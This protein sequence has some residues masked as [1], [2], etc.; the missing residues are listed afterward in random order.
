MGKKERSSGD[1]WL[2]R[3]GGLALAAALTVLVVALVAMP[4]LPTRVAPT[5]ETAV[6]AS[7]AGSSA[8]GRAGVL[9]VT[10]EPTAPEE[11]TAGATYTP[12]ATVAVSPTLTATLGMSWPEYDWW[13]AGTVIAEVKVEEVYPVRANNPSGIPPT[14]DPS[15]LQ[16]K[17]PGGYEKREYQPILVDVVEWYHGELP[18]VNGLLFW[19]MV[20]W[21]GD[22]GMVNLRHT[23]PLDRVAPGDHAIV[24][25]E[26]MNPDLASEQPMWAYLL[27]EA[28]RLSTPDQAVRAADAGSW[29]QFDGDRAWNTHYGSIWTIEELRVEIERLTGSSP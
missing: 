1:G 24:F 8:R 2:V 4:G 6:P 14:R 25:F 29:Y 16:F 20:T 23:I 7:G 15:I 27:D 17:D 19:D 21:G 11:P 9:S 22:W 18:G 12:T 5:G 3:G 10:D 28:E 26:V 13:V